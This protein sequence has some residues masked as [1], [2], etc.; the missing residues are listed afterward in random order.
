M[1]FFAAVSAHI[2]RTCP[3]EARA[4][5]DFNPSAKIQMT[6]LHKK[7]LQFLRTYNGTRSHTD[8][9]SHFRIVLSLP[10]KARLRAHPY[11]KLI[12]FS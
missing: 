11:E 1:N 10:I 12:L 4:G 8:A 7:H 2:C 5:F 3:C 6:D 9:K